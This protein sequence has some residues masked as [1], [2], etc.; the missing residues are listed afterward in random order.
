M[1]EKS[2]IVA[3]PDPVQRRR[4]A[5]I[6]DQL[7]DFRVVASTPDLMNTYNEVEFLLPKAVLISD[8]LAS[9][10][11]FEVMRAL[12]STLDVRWLV[13]ANAP[14]S[15]SWSGTAAAGL[16]SGSDL[17]ALSIK[18][19]PDV[20]A[21]QLCALTRTKFSPPKRPASPRPAAPT[22]RPLRTAP[23]ATSTQAHPIQHPARPHP[24]TRPAPTG[25]ASRKNDKLLL[26]GSSTGG[27][28]ALLSVLSHFPADCPPTMIVQHTGAGFGES[29]V[30]L[31]NRQCAADVVLARGGEQIRPGQVLLGA[32]T[33]AHLIVENSK[34]MTAGLEKSGPIS[35]HIPSVDAL[36]NSAQDIAKK[37]VAAILTGMG[38]DGADGLLKLH[39]LGA[40]TFAQDK[41]T[42]VVYGMPR[43][44]AENGAAQTILPI[45]NIGPTLLA[46]CTATPAANREIRR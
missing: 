11:E 17:F 35:G 3:S 44:A 13:I 33:K 32:G 21:Q 15:A 36:F 46:E 30:G 31:L 18:A 22:A 40:R 29:L 6:V 9:L 4:L 23:S 45:Q 27:V 34:T 41:E 2:V 14:G 28:D 37:T 16:P 26:I 5:Q 8:V 20:I 25:L 43:A 1:V 38:R 7:P 19:P 39:Q 24:P 10:P 42:S 12:F